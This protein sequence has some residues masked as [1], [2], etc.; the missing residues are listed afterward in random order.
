MEPPNERS[1]CKLKLVRRGVSCTKLSLGLLAS[2]FVTWW[3]EPGRS[4]QRAVASLQLSTTEKRGPRGVAQIGRVLCGNYVE[5]RH[6]QDLR[7]PLTEQRGHQEMPDCHESVGFLVGILFE[8]K[9]E[10]PA[11]DVF[12]VRRTG[13]RGASLSGSCLLVANRLPCVGIWCYV[14]QWQLRGI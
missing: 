2:L 10:E 6:L 4:K 13:C 14:E 3:S 12:T 1:N 11:H 8:S 7:Q 5:V 9:A